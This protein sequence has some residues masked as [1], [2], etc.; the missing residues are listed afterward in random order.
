MM[1]SVL[2]IIYF[3]ISTYISMERYKKY[4]VQVGICVTVRI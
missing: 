4:K 2:I 3:Y 1:I